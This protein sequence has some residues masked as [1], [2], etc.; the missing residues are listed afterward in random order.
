MVE[1]PQARI[2][3]LDQKI[4]EELSNKAK[5]KIVKLAEKTKEKVETANYRLKRLEK[6]TIIGYRIFLDLEKIGYHLALVT[7]K[8]NNLS[9]QNKNKILA[10]G[11]QKERIH[12]CGIGIGKFNVL[13][14]IIYKTP[15]ELSEEINKIKE[16]FSDNLVEYELIHIENELEPKTI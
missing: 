1:T 6:N 8:L 10:Y 7:L 9:Q 12:A 4:L 15:S 11:N 3:K 16:N 14:Q 5:M 13:F 2:D